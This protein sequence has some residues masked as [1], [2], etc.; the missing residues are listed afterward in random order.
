[1]AIVA[2]IDEA[3]YGPLVGPLVTAATALLVRLAGLSQRTYLA[4]LAYGNTGNLGLP[5]ALFAFGDLGLS[6]AVV[7]FAVAG[8]AIWLW[9]GSMVSIGAI[10][11][12][13]V[14]ML[15]WS[16]LVAVTITPAIARSCSR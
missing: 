10:A 4:P 6:Y 5:L 1:M 14:I 7:V 9:L 2:G 3:G 8:L 13:V 16:F 11:I 15:G 12:A